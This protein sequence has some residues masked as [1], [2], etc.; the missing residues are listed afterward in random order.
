MI[1]RGAQSKAL[2]GSGESA[3]LPAGI[4]HSAVHSAVLRAV[5]SAVLRAVLSAVLRAV[6]SAVLRAVLSAVL[7]AVLS[8]VLRAVLSTVLRAVDFGGAGRLIAR[9]AQSKAPARRGEPAC[10]RGSDG[11]GV[12]RS[13]MSRSAE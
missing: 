8:A 6:L 4:G 12:L 11:V 7:R 5:L 2:A 9:G 1:A 13:S 3:G 10:R